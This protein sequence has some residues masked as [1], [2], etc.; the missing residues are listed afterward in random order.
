MILTPVT[1]SG[2]AESGIGFYE[3]YRMKMQHFTERFAPT[4]G[5]SELL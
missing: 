5:V 2:E 3:V 4:W 1:P